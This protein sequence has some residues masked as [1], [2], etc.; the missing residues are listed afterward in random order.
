MWKT[1][2]A[3]CNL[4]SCPSFLHFVIKD[5]QEKLDGTYHRNHSLVQIFPSLIILTFHFPELK[6]IKNKMEVK[7]EIKHRFVDRMGDIQKQKNYWNIRCDLT[8]LDNLNT[9]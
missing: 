3:R 8:F 7:D 1:G 9:K 5:V 6:E 2:N 4:S